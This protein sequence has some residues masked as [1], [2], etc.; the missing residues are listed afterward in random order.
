MREWLIAALRPSTKQ[1]LLAVILCLLGIAIVVQVRSSSRNDHYSAMRRDD[2][3]QLLD[4]LNAES[5]QLNQDVEQLQTTR[6]Q[7]QSGVNANEVAAAEAQQRA[8]AIAI[9]AGTAPA[10]GPGVRITISAPAGS[11][12]P[13]LLLDAVQ[14]LRDAGA[15]VMEMNDTIR[16]VAQS[17]IAERDDVLIIDDQVIQLPITIDA[18][19]DAHSL[20]E[21]AKFRGGLVSQVESEK[22]GGFVEIESLNEVTISS[23]KQLAPLE[24]ARPS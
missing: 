13:D 14:E 24:H 12:T 21:G 1:L 17:W 2:L 23:V 15:E 19:G 5:Q 6:D 20:A 16:L 8:D 22:V 18:I 9:L 7:L 10:T 4:T 3:V 11:I